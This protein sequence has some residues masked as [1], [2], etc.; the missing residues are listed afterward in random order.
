M[1]ESNPFY[2]I[3]KNALGHICSGVLERLNYEWII[4]FVDVTAPAPFRWRA[5]YAQ[6]E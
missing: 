6:R 2:V 5:V 4:G 3:R 1:N